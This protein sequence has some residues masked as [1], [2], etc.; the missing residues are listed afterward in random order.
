[1]SSLAWACPGLSASSTISQRDR[2]DCPPVIVCGLVLLPASLNTDCT[3][4]GQELQA[5]T[6]AA[7][8]YVR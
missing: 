1:M 3:H 5:V 4:H 6:V 2:Y 7:L 8:L